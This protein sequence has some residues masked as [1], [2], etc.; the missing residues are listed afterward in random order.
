MKRGWWVA[1]IVMALAAVAGWQVYARRE[2]AT[3]APQWQT[4][5]VTRGT[6]EAT[7]TASGTVRAAQSAVL[8]WQLSGVVGKVNVALGSHVQRDD[9]L[10]ALR[11]DSWPQSLLTARTSLLTAQQRL[12]DLRRKASLQYAQALESLAQAR[13][14]LKSTEWR[15]NSI[16]VNW[17]AQKAEDEYKKWHNLVLSLQRE[18]NSPTTPPQLQPALRVQLETAKR[19]EMVAKNNLNPSEEDK[20]KATADYELAKAQV[21]YWEQEAAR[22]QN[23]PPE[24]QVAQLQAQIAAAQAALDMA[25]LKAPFDGTVTAS[26]V[27]VGDVVTPGMAAFRL[28]DLSTLYVDVDLQEL[29]IVQVKAGQSVVFEFDALPGKTYH[30]KV[31]EVALAGTPDRSGNVNFRVTVV[32]EDPDEAI[33]PGMTAAVTIQTNKITDALLVPSR[34]VRVRDGKPVVYLLVGGALKTV[35]VTLGASSGARVQIVDGEVHEGDTVV[36][37]PP[38]E[39]FNFFGG[40]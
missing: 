19:Q 12:D 10:A 15:Y 32:M 20:A 17:D 40:R 7:V 24:D 25:I 21:A 30:G 34:A 38:A 31:T 28:D 23:G 8:V 29:E 33:R 4:A 2:K 39:G 26:Q 27:T 13:Q 11:E 18:L 22:W 36:L 9:V 16:V 14:R 37:N 1:L 6:L 3:Q 5:K 35:P